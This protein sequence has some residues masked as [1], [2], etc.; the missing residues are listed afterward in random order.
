METEWQSVFLY[1]LNDQVLSVASKQSNP[2]SPWHLVEIKPLRGLGRPLSKATKVPT[3]SFWWSADTGVNKETKSYSQFME[4]FNE[5]L[6]DRI[7][8]FMEYHYRPMN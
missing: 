8:G 3:I 2:E 4:T 1:S 7:I 6:M 5:G